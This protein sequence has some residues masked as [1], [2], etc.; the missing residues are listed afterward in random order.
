MRNSR[1][2]GSMCFP[3]C[4]LRLALPIGATG[5]RGGFCGGEAGGHRWG[6]PGGCRLARRVCVRGRRRGYGDGDRAGL[7]GWLYKAAGRPELTSSAPRAPDSVGG[8]GGGGR[9]LASVGAVLGSPRARSLSVCHCASRSSSS[10]PWE[11]CWRI[12]G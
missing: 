4:W 7:G 11:R 10:C 1:T 2:N 5:L 3:R 8:G 6:R 12:C 9:W